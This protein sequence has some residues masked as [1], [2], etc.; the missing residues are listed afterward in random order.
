MTTTAHDLGLDATPE[1]TLDALC[2]EVGIDL[3]FVEKGGSPRAAKSLCSRCPVAGE[4]LEYAL[5]F[6]KDHAYLYGVFGGLAPRQRHALLVHRHGQTCGS[7][8]K[9]FR[10][11]RQHNHL[12][13]RQEGA[14]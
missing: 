7:C 8:G 11:L 5:D 13:H 4:C 1:W 12:E 6:E 10:D 9:R 14:A 3:F 2:A